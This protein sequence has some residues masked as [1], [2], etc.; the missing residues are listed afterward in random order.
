M[1][2][3]VWVASV[4]DRKIFMYCSSRL[5]QHTSEFFKNQTNLVNKPRL[6]EKFNRPP[7]L[8]I[9]SWS[10]PAHLL[11]RL[12]CFEISMLYFQYEETG[13]RP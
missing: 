9:I 2:L 1:D 6:C 5:A 13:T 8:L 12:R 7:I 11:G 4:E 10:I 3:M